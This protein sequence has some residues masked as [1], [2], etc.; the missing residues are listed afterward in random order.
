MN[1]SNLLKLKRNEMDMTQATLADAIGVNKQTIANWENERC[2]PEIKDDFVINSL[3]NILNLS[4]KEII[5]TIT[6]LNINNEKDND[7]II[8]YSFLPTEFIN[9]ELSEKEI[10]ILFEMEYFKKNTDFLFIKKEYK[11]NDDNNETPYI[12]KYLSYNDYIKILGSGR[13]VLSTIEK[14]SNV[15]KFI[16][17]EVLNNI[18]RKN[19]LTTFHIQKLSE[20]DIYTIL[21]YYKKDFDYVMDNN[22]NICYFDKN[23]V[24][25]N[26]LYNKYGETHINKED[27]LQKSHEYILNNYFIPIELIPEN[28]TIE[29][30]AKLEIYNEEVNSWN[31][32]MVEIKKLQDLYDSEKYPDLPKPIEPKMP[33]KKLFYQLNYKGLLLKKFLE[34]M[35]NIED[36]VSDFVKNARIELEPYLNKEISVFGTLTSNEND[37]YLFKSIY[38]NGKIID[39]LWVYDIEEE[40]IIG[41]TYKL[42]GIVNIYTKEVDGTFMKNYGIK[43]NKIKEI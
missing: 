23:F 20:E 11:Y 34:K 1:F 6:E 40:L 17:I 25:K 19:N 4:K 41:K 9:L 31:R 14:I 21:S 13:N 8:K 18:I 7:E 27:I 35:N 37:T 36:K 33:E 16:N 24:L 12:K 2:T 43:V 42:E 28:D 38:V 26:K 32:K 15:L 30:N 39:H 10:E 3:A 29:Y 22:A 5:E